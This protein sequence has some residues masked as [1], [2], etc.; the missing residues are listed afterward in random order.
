M[1][2]QE[3]LAILKHIASIAARLLRLTCLRCNQHINAIALKHPW[4]E[5]HSYVGNLWLE[6]AA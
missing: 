2:R 5:Q 3:S 6:R 1:R 4:K